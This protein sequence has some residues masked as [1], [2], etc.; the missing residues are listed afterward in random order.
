[1]TAYK[2][3]SAVRGEFATAD[4]LVEFDYPAGEVMPKGDEDVLAFLLA[5][6][7][8]TEAAEKKTNKKSDATPVVADVVT[9][10][11]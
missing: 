2:L 11:N 6:G 7:L 5:S 1:M 9:E 8:A 3:E 10:E 4:G